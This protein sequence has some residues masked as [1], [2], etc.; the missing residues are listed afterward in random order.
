LGYHHLFLSIFLLVTRFCTKLLN[1]QNIKYS[2]SKYKICS[3]RQYNSNFLKIST[4]LIPSVLFKRPP[5][6][7]LYFL[8]VTRFCTKLLNRQNIKYSPSKYKICSGRQYN[9][10]F[11]KIS[12]LLIP[13][14]L[15][16]IPPSFSLYFLLAT[17]FCTKLLDSQSIKYGRSD[18]TIQVF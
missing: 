13:S 6:F 4:L 7:S 8:L 5:S 14:V 2:P 17:R 18:S 3:G 1:R 9:S 12:I 15:F 11:L 16:G 10:I